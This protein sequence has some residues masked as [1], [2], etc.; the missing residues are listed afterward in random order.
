MLLHCIIQ[1]RRVTS[2]WGNKTMHENIL[3]RKL[4]HWQQEKITLI[5]SWGWAGITHFNSWHH[6]EDSVG[7]S[8][9]CTLIFHIWCCKKAVIHTTLN[10]HNIPYALKG[11]A[12]VYHHKEDVTVIKMSSGTPPHC[13]Q[14]HV[15]IISVTHESP[16]HL[17]WR[18][19]PF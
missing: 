16:T 18:P 13:I 14:R 5:R 15:G 7:P 1:L 19:L 17:L 10:S 12:T 6:R 3:F 11:K 8:W 4:L 9:V 2:G